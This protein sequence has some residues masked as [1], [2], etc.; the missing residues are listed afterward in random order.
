VTDLFFSDDIVTLPFMFA[1]LLITAAEFY[2]I[3]ERC[4]ILTKR[5]SKY[6]HHAML[7]KKSLEERCSTT[8]PT[9]PLY[10]RAVFDEYLPYTAVLDLDKLWAA[11][12]DKHIH[13][14]A[15]HYYYP[16]WFIVPADSS[17]T[18]PS[19]LERYQTLSQ[20]MARSLL[21]ILLK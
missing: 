10:L 15:G 14:G 16:H 11:Q 1:S 21:K 2:S 13:P 17:P 12:W 6:Y 9:S 19:F 20:Q 3:K 4:T 5:G 7:L 8:R 18:P